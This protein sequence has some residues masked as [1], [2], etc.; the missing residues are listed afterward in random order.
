MTD[1]MEG[2][3]TNYANEQLDEFY[4]AIGKNCSLSCSYHNI[5]ELFG[6]VLNCLLC[7]GIPW[8]PRKMMTSTHPTIEIAIKDGEWTIKTSSMMSSTSSTFKL[9]EKYQETMGGSGR[10]IEVSQSFCSKIVQHQ[11]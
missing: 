9:G 11:T 2:K 6:I 7:A 8:I 3:F 10:T 1:K 4:A 5:F